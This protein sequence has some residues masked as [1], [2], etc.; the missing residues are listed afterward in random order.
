[1]PNGIALSKLRPF[2]RKPCTCVSGDFMPRVRPRAE[3]LM[4]G[5]ERK[6][7]QIRVVLLNADAVRWFHYASACS[8]VFK[9][10]SSLYLRD[11]GTSHRV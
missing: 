3:S 6:P 5:H 2:V 4:F 7:G 1:M 10:S 8:K 11:L 9:S